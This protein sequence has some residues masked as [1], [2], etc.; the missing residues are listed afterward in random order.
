MRDF[1]SIAAMFSF[2]RNVVEEAFCGPILQSRSGDTSGQWMCLSISEPSLT[3]SL[4]ITEDVELAYIL[5]YPEQKRQISNRS[6]TWVIRQVGVYQQHSKSTKKSVWI[7]LHCNIKSL[8]VKHV[9]HLLNDDNGL[10]AAQ[11]YPEVLHLL[12]LSCYI[13]NWRDYMAFYEAELLE[14]VLHILFQN[15]YRSADTLNLDKQSPGREASG[16]SSSFLRYYHPTSISRD[17][18]FIFA[19]N[20]RVPEV[21][22][23]YSRETGRFKF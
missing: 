19:I 5:K 23:Q 11:V 6:E 14:K 8:T 10:E 22:T 21:T 7:L 9:T 13:N 3:E 15:F 1:Q 12:L 20:I 16:S 18:I 17:Q 2:K 4:L